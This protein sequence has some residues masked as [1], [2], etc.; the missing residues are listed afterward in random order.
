VKFSD[1]KIV[2]FLSSVDKAGEVQ[3]ERILPGNI[4]MEYRRPIAIDTYNTA[5]GGVDRTDQILATA[6]C[7]RKSTVWFKKIGI[8]LCQRRV[9]N[10]YIR[11]KTEKSPNIKYIDFLKDV[12]VHLTGVASHPVRGK[13]ARY[14]RPYAA[15]QIHCLEYIEA[16]DV[17]RRKRKRCKQCCIQNER[18]D[19]FYQCDT[20]PGNPALCAVPCFKTW[21]AQQNT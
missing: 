21:H 1:K 12:V 7:V 16:G 4:Y 9:L 18:S 5:M 15:A 13:Q 14:E 6:T 3:K 19:T 20:C 8:D 10:A 17:V 11:F 2:Y